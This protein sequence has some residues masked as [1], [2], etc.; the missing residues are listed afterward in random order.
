MS[1]EPS[2]EEITAAYERLR[3]ADIS[4]RAIVIGCLARIAQ[5]RGI[6]LD[7]AVT[8]AVRIRAGDMEA[9]SKL[10]LDLRSVDDCTEIRWP[11][12]DEL[13]TRIAWRGSGG[14]A[15]FI[16]I[17]ATRFAFEPEAAP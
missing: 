17:L 5:L 9:G 7:D 13:V 3:S 1:I 16:W 14:A 2:I 10:G 11:G 4:D 8:V 12:N 6:S 15:A